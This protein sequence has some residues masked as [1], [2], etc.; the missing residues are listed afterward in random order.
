M[1]FRDA[2]S[3]HFST[4]TSPHFSTHTSPGIWNIWKSRVLL[5]WCL[6]THSMSILI[7]EPIYVCIGRAWAGEGNRDYRG[8][9][10]RAHPGGRGT[11]RRSQGKH[12]TRIKFNAKV[13]NLVLFTLRLAGVR[14]LDAC[15]CRRTKCCML[16][17]IALPRRP[18]GAAP[19]PGPSLL[20]A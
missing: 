3:P 5:F 7:S 17:A 6:D 19:A 4:H 11:S 18:I 8:Y 10:D 2:F 1:H 15:R 12:T 14:R 9:R 13:S 16:R 20:P